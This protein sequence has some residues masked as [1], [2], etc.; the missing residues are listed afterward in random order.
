MAYVFV[1][2]ISSTALSVGTLNQEVSELTKSLHNM[3]HIL[4]AHISMNH[5]HKTFLSSPPSVHTV[6][7]SPMVSN[8]SSA[9][10]L[11][12]SPQ[13]FK[14]HGH[15]SAPAA[16]HWSYSETAQSHTESHQS[17]TP[18]PNACL[19]LSV[20]S[21]SKLGPYDGT[22]SMTLPVWTSPSL[23]HITPGY[24]SGSPDLARHASRDESRPLGA[25]P[26]SISQSH[27]TLCL[28]PS[29]D[30]DEFSSLLSSV[31]AGTSTHSLMDPASE[32]P[33]EVLSHNPTHQTSIFLIH[34]S[35]SSLPPSS[36]SQ[37]ALPSEPSV[38]SLDSGSPQLN[39]LAPCLTLANTSASEHTSLECLLGNRDSVESRDSESMSSR[40]S[41]IG[42][43]TQSTEQSWCLDLTD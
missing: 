27:P 23:L 22:E 5:H 26:T 43:Q 4:Q 34:D 35:R 38:S 37:P 6:S 18:L 10:C 25:A 21:S 1:S 32:T 2:V 13:S 30:R 15:Q 11:Y 31:P 3:L 33:S 7:S 29:S 24:S 36:S 42:G 28:Q 39:V 16:V 14:A 8:T 12:T 41:S 19:R 20:N 9:Y 17:P 40:R